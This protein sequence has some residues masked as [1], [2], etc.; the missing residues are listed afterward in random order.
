[1]RP[2]TALLCN[3]V[4]LALRLNLGLRCQCASAIS[5]YRKFANVPYGPSHCDIIDR[6]IGFGRQGIG[7]W[8]SVAK[9]RVTHYSG[10]IQS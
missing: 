3:R 5:R 9:P 1:M 8:H 7:Y 10:D 4:S 2:F 6:G